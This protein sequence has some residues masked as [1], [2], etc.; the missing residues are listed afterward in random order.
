VHRLRS[1]A[2]FFSA[3]LIR[4]LSR[5][6]RFEGEIAD[7]GECDGTWELYRQRGPDA[8]PL[9]RESEP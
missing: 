7:I 9:V 5:H 3:L 8:E 1:M 2:I 4:L 6:P